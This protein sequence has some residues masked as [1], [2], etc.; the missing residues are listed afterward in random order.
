M[1]TTALG[2]TAELDDDPAIKYARSETL[3][4]FS[5]YYRGEGNP[6]QALR[7]AKESLELRREVGKKKAIASSLDQIGGAYV[8]AGDYRMAEKYK[9]EAL[10]MERELDNAPGIAVSASAAK[11]PRSAWS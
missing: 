11:S 7:Y 3:D 8:L 6:E 5:I 9:T 4:F 10:E 2:C 1:L